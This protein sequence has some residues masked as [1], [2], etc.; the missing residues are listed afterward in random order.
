MPLVCTIRVA[1]AL[2]MQKIV[3]DKTGM[4]KV[5]LKS[6]PEGG[7]AN[8]ELVQF[9]SKK[10]RLPQRAF[11][12]IAGEL[13]KKKTLKIDTDMTFIQLCAAC[14]SDVQMKII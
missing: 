8:K 12:F 9:L 6:P 14:D 10:L 4:L 3:L 5:Y 1:P 11:I 13:A 7:K 2:G